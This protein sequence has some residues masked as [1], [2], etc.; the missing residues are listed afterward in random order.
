MGAAGDRPGWAEEER[1]PCCGPV[2]EGDRGGLVGVGVLSG[3]EPWDTEGGAG[4]DEGGDGRRVPAAVRDEGE[5][6][7]AGLRSR[8]LPVGDAHGHV[9]EAAIVVRG[10]P[11]RPVAGSHAR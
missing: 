4:E 8:Q 5:G 1:G 6:E 10:V 7:A 2:Q 3:G 9:A 11:D